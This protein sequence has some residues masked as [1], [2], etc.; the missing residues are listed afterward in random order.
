MSSTI[1]FDTDYTTQAGLL[2]PVESW[3]RRITAPNPGPFTFCGTGTYVVG[4]GQVA[5]IDPGPAI[6]SHV[7]A[8]L[9]QLGGET[10][11]HILV[12]HAHADHS[13]ACHLL[14]QHVDAPVYAYP[15]DHGYHNEMGRIEAD[16]YDVSFK[17]DIAITDGHTIEGGKWTLRALHTPGHASDHLC[18]HID[19]YNELFCGDH[20]MGWSSSIVSPPDGNMSDYM[21]ELERLLNRTETRYWPTHGGPIVQPQKWVQRLIDHRLAREAAILDCVHSGYASASEM[22]PKIYSDLAQEMHAAAE[23]SLRASLAW[24]VEKHVLETYTGDNGREHFRPV[25]ASNAKK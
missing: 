17:P 5:V 14:Q 9:D 6:Q 21:R 11:T 7:D 19:Q 13:S 24:L 4:S 10:V 25:S 23:R 1:S 18:F 15:Q 22:V 8:L 12:T 16:G 20:V 3:L 2:E